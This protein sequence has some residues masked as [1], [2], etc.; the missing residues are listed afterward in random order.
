M[1]EYIDLASF[2]FQ[3]K[4]SLATIL[5]IANLSQLKS[6]VCFSDW[7]SILS[8]PTSHCPFILRKA[9]I[10][11]VFFFFST[12]ME[13]N[14]G[15]LSLGFAILQLVHSRV[16][17]MSSRRTQNG[18]STAAYIAHASQPSQSTPP[19][20]NPAAN[21]CALCLRQ[22]CQYVTARAIIAFFASAMIAETFGFIALYQTIIS[23]KSKMSIVLAIKHSGFLILL[24]PHVSSLFSC[25]WL[26]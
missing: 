14:F 11:S 10:F 20:C 7:Q 9:D 6:N 26:L 1:R 15:C 2:T 24:H 18:R 13:S 16:N 19:S 4:H 21:K 25:V 12:F 3:L 8:S 23:T 22:R 5:L 17:F